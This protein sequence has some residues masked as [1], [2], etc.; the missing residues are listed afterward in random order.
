MGPYI[1]H[2]GWLC[3]LACF[4]IPN[5]LLHNLLVLWQP[6]EYEQHKQ[7]PLQVPKWLCTCR[8]QRSSSLLGPALT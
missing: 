2:S 1:L 7:L 5:L 3:D 8:P 6:S 4:P